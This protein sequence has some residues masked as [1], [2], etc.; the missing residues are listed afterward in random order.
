MMKFSNGL[1]SDMLC[2]EE[3]E[4]VGERHC[5]AMKK[6]KPLKRD[7]VVVVADLS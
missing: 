4:A 1:F 5:Y 3:E 2:D 7:V 6:K